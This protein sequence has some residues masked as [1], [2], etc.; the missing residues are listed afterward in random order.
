MKKLFYCEEEGEFYWLTD[1]EK[2]I[3]IEWHIH[4]SSGDHLDQNVNHKRLVVTK[5][6]RVGGHPIK[7]HTDTTLLIYPYQNGQPFYLELA[8]MDHIDKEIKDCNDFG[9]SHQYYDDLK[10]Y[11]LKAHLVTFEITTRI[12][13]AGGEEAICEKAKTKIA[14]VAGEYLLPENVT[15]I[16][17]DNEIPYGKLDS[18]ME[19]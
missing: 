14:R 7:E 5:E 18:D 12:I 13:C 17:V 11:V 10:Q 3:L 16:T 15:K 2:T 1:R 4:K 8:T 6:P 19:E 9:V